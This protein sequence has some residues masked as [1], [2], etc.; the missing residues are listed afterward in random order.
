[1]VQF[2]G[3]RSHA[4]HFL[5]LKRGN[6]IFMTAAIEFITLPGLDCGTLFTLVPQN[7]RG[8]AIRYQ[9]S[10]AS[11]YH[12]SHSLKWEN[13]LFLQHFVVPRE[14][15]GYRPIPM[16]YELDSNLVQCAPSNSKFNHKLQIQSQDYATFRDLSNAY[17]Q[18]L[19][20]LSHTK[21][22]Q[23]K[24]RGCHYQFQAFLF[25]L[26]SAIRVFCKI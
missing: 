7:S 17:Y 19:I 8:D 25:D 6:K 5:F 21:F 11:K 2:N 3:W 4:Y 12:Y 14:P 10:F 24:Y 18:I 22:L 1:M 15:I 23:F 13:S 20:R 16:S 9:Y 26:L